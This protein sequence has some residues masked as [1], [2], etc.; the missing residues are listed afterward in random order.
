[1]GFTTNDAHGPLMAEETYGRYL[2]QMDRE[3]EATAW[4]PDSRES[5]QKILACSRQQDLEQGV[6]TQGQQDWKKE[7]NV[8]SKEQRNEK[9][10]LEI[11]TDRVSEREQRIEQLYFS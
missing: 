11:A 8:R 7:Q 9:Q 1:M 2:L 10:I 4:S 6:E 5:T 3:C